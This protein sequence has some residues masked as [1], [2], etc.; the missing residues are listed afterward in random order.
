MRGLE[1]AVCGGE[2]QAPGAPGQ[3]LL[4]GL[5]A[6]EVGVGSGGSGIGRARD[7]EQ[8]REKSEAELR[9]GHAPLRARAFSI[10]FRVLSQLPPVTASTNFP[11]ES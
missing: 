4:R 9:P 5:S 3:D 11:L 8:E 7:G 2:R 6:G 1:G 10:A